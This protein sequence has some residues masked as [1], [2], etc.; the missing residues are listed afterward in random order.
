MHFELPLC[1]LEYGLHG[2][3]LCESVVSYHLQVIELPLILCIMYELLVPYA[4]SV[5]LVQ[6]NR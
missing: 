4:C 2:K 5:G 1:I 6:L 3:E